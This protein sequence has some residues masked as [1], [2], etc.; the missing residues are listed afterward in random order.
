MHIENKFSLTLLRLHAFLNADLQSSYAYIF[1]LPYNVSAEFRIQRYTL[2][3]GLIMGTVSPCAAAEEK[4]TS[5]VPFV[6]IPVVSLHLRYDSISD[7]SMYGFSFL[8]VMVLLLDHL[9]AMTTS[10]SNLNL[11]FLLGLWFLFH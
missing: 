1:G 6:S 5:L 3:R 10:I 9:C 7:Y 2:L 11:T 8:T 4:F